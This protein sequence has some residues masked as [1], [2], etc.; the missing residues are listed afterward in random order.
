M[1]LQILHVMKMRVYLV[2]LAITKV[3]TEN[4]KKLLTKNHKCNSFHGIREPCY[5]I[6]QLEVCNKYCCYDG[7]EQAFQWCLRCGRFLIS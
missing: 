2:M 4:E 6:A 7:Y 5:K 3:L 1:F